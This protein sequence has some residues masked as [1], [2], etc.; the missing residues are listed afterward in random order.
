MTT[1]PFAFGLSHVYVFSFTFPFF[2]FFLFFSARTNSNCAVHAHGFTVQELHL[3][4]CAS[5]F[6]VSC[7]F[8]FS[9]FFFSARMNNN[10][11]VHAEGFIVQEAK[12]TVHRTYNHFVQKKILKT[13]ITA[14][15]THLK[16]ILLQ[17][18]QF[19]VFSF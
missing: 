5:T 18:F 4:Y 7:F 3:A 13:G 6:L 9:F 2:L 12:C 15:S 19:S 10:C 14:L 16:I 8:F 17:C 11:T 1:C